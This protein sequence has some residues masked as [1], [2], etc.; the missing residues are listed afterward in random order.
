VFTTTD[1]NLNPLAARRG[2]RLAAAQRAHP[3]A[4]NMRV[5]GVVPAGVL[6]AVNEASL[7]G[8]GKSGAVARKCQHQIALAN[9]ADES[10][11]AAGAIRIVVALFLVLPLCIGVASVV[12]GVLIA[13]AAEALPIILAGGAA[14]V[15]VIVIEAASLCARCQSN[16]AG[17]S[18][19]R[20][21]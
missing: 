21:L 17:E 12:I 2:G 10:G 18:K 9:R 19:C 13:I 6:V 4:G 8:P 16:H 11:T 1:R 7:T 15:V 5:V 14:I 20:D 3:R